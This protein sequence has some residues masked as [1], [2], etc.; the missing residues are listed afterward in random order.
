ME[1]GP[2]RAESTS[3]ERLAKAGKNVEMPSAFH[4]WAGTTQLVLESPKEEEVPDL[5]EEEKET[6]QVS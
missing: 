4:E 3:W 2:L 5:V 6:T 1:R